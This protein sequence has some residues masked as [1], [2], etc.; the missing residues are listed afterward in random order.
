MDCWVEGELCCSRKVTLQ[1]KPPINPLLTLR[2]KRHAKCSWCTFAFVLISQLALIFLSR[3]VRIEMKSSTLPASLI[4][5]LS[6]LPP[7]PSFSQNGGAQ[8]ASQWQFFLLLHTC[9]KGSF[10]DFTTLVLP[11]PCF[12]SLYLY[13][14]QLTSR[15]KWCTS[16]SEGSIST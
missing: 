7:K 5:P 13:S 6:T 11:F 10:I 14:Y 3:W 16:L 8:C 4:G 15:H 2:E 9:I 12:S 1:F